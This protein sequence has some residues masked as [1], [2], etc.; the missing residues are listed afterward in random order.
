[1]NVTVGQDIRAMAV[2]APGRVTPRVR[3]RARVVLLTTRVSVTLA[4]QEPR[5]T[6]T[7]AAMVTPRV[8]RA[9]AY[10][11]SV[12]TTQRGKRVKN[13]PWDL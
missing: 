8:T 10:V 3:R 4:G 11:T 6:L 13:A 7:A 9:R 2:G 12:S 5:V 1:M